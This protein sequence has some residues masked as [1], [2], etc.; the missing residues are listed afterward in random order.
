MNEKCNVS[1]PVVSEVTRFF[2]T[3]I[4]KLRKIKSCGMCTLRKRA[5]IQLLKSVQRHIH[6]IFCSI[7]LG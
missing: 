6:M 2:L 7:E 4:V 3:K 5:K 1:G